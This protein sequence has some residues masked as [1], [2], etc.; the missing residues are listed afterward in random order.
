MKNQYHYIIDKSGSMSDCQAN[1][2]NCINEQFYTLKQLAVSE[3]KQEF[4]ASLHF[5][6]DF[7]KTMINQQSPLNLPKLYY[8]DFSPSGSTALYDAIGTV[9]SAERL[10][11]SEAVIKGEKKVV[12]VIITDGHENMSLLYNFENIRKLIL[13]MQN[14]G[15][16]FMFLGAIPNAKNVARK[17]NIKDEH[18]HSFYKK[19]MDSMFK[20]V[21]SS[22]TDLAK[23]KINWNKFTN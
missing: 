10:N 3:K 18:A 19:D 5:F 14:E 12:F 22:L 9:A 23:N 7:F 6:N 4:K 21:G 20:K 16:I 1:T 11:S 15:Y 2:V 13:E 8:N 17:M